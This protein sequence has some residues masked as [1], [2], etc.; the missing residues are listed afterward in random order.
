MNQQQYEEA[1]I[2]VNKYEKLTKDLTWLK[3]I[4]DKYNNKEETCILVTLRKKKNWQNIDSKDIFPEELQEL[5]RQTI[6]DYY[7]SEILSKEIDKANL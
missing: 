1:R 2:K 6:L 3:H 4:Y 7:D 5:I